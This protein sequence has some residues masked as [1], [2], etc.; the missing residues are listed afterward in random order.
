MFKHK[1]KNDDTETLDHAI[2]DLLA[3]MSAA[4]KDSPEYK[5]Y[6]ENLIKLYPI[7][8]VDHEINQ[9]NKISPDVALT[10]AANLA[11]IILI[12]HHEQVGV[13][14]SKALGFVIKAR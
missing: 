12:I 5:A 7:R 9:K 1:P 2:A 6:V 10:V 14:A 3:D 11:G 13:I 4:E 8:K